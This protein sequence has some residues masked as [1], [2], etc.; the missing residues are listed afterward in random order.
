MYDALDAFR[1]PKA[2]SNIFVHLSLAEVV[3]IN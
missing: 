3:E 1:L 2:L